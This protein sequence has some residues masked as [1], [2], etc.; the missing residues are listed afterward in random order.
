PNAIQSI[1]WNRNG[2]LFATTCKDKCIRV[3]EAR[4][5][6]IIAREIGHQGPKTSKAVFLGDT[7]R[8]LSTG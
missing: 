6:R 1:T 8:L 5:G 7:N 3:I 4:S 2:S